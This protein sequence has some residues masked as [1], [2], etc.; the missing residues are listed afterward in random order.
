MVSSSV[1][2]NLKAAIAEPNLGHARALEQALMAAE[3]P[4]KVFGRFNQRSSIEANSESDRG[5]AE[6]LANAFDT[7]LTAARLSVGMLRSDRS[8]T[9]RVAAARFF[10]PNPDVS[11]WEAQ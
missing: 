2:R 8:F 3:F 6:R 10:S 1:L 4:R 5:I 9:P 7:S 11:T